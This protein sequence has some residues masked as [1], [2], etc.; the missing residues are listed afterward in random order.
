MPVRFEPTPSAQNAEEFCVGS[1]R[2]MARRFTTDGRLSVERSQQEAHHLVQPLQQIRVGALSLLGVLRISVICPL[3]K[4]VRSGL[5][6]PG[7]PWLANLLRAPGSRGT[8]RRGRPERGYHS[9]CAT[10]GQLLAEF[11]AYRIIDHLGLQAK[12]N[13]AEYARSCGFLAGISLLP[14]PCA[15]RP[16][17]L[18]VVGFIL[19]SAPTAVVG[20]KPSRHSSH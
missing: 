5:G 11:T 7:R 6:T 9:E 20:S 15:V 13:L 8:L 19:G 12:C 3:Q 2:D 10:P 17:S 1:Q 18:N 4:L 16:G 14:I